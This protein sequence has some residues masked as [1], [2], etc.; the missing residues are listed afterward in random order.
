M[1]LLLLR[2]AAGCTRLLLL[3]MLPTNENTCNMK[4]SAT[5]V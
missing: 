2:T 5:Y 4:R 3:H 1:R